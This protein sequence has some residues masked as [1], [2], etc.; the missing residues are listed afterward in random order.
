MSSMGSSCSSASS[1]HPSSPC[2][3]SSLQRWQWSTTAKKSTTKRITT[4]TGQRTPTTTQK[5]HRH[6]EACSQS[7]PSIGAAHRASQQEYSAHGYSQ[8][9]SL[10]AVP[11][12]ERGVQQPG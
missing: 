8:P 1:R 9:S 2:S 4:K 7:N 10:L 3:H 6:T 12:G 11:P 5:L